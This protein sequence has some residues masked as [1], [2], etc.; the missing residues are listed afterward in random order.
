VVKDWI[1]A[2]GMLSVCAGGCGG[3]SV[4]TESEP[5]VQFEWLEQISY[6]GYMATPQDSPCDLADPSTMRLEGES[7]GFSW[8]LCLPTSDL[9][10][11]ELH[12][13]E[14]TLI[15][16]EVA[17]V[18]RALQEVQPMS[19]RCTYDGADFLL[20]MAT[21]EG[22]QLMVDAGGSAG[23][24]SPPERRYAGRT[25]VRG[26]PSLHEVLLALAMGN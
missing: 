21:A 25:F 10:L 12:V 18:R 11:V 16:D 14:R 2:L 9:T 3:T 7:F 5:R 26:L 20:D 1:W 15:E 22:V 6:F 4:R 23:C 17:R 24:S 13:G 8:R 19:P